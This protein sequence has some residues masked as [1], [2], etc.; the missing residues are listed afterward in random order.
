M[1]PWIP[2]GLVMDPLGSAQHTLQPTGQTDL[3]VT[4]TCTAFALW[5]KA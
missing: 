2:W 1:Y 5:I 3:S 4:H